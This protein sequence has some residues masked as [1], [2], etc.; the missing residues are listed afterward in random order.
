[1]EMKEDTQIPFI[2]GRPFL[3]T[4]GTMIDVK[5]VRL[6]PQV[7]EEKPEFNLSQAMSSTPSPQ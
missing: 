7:G 4:V 1:M 6:S 3:A 2:I 5:N